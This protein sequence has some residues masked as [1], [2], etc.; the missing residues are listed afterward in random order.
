MHEI[1]GKIKLIQSEKR[2]LNG[3]RFFYLCFGGQWHYYVIKKGKVES[4]Y[5]DD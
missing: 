3:L 5:L 1:H 2:I 4:S